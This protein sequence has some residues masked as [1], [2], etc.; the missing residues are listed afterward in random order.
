MTEPA[1]HPRLGELEQ[2]LVRAVSQYNELQQAIKQLEK[3]IL[4]LRGAY[5]EAEHWVAQEFSKS[6]S[7]E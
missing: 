1:K 3:K 2:E 4:G 5:E 6:S 7:E